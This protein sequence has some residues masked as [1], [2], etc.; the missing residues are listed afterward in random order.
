M[1]CIDRLKSLV[2]ADTVAIPLQKARGKNLGS[3]TSKMNDD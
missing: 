2:E 3:G 1:C